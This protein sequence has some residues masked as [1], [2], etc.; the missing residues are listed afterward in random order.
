MY[1]AL[2]ISQKFQVQKLVFC[3]Y[4]QH[5]FAK[6]APHPSE[7]RQCSAV[8]KHRKITSE[9]CVQILLTEHSNRLSF[10][11]FQNIVKLIC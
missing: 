5:C 2:L 8:N 1:A 9:P 7:Y 4:L 6:I 11:R 3:I 10:T